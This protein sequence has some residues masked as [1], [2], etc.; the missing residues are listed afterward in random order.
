MQNINFHNADRSFVFKGKGKLKT[1]IDKLVKSENFQVEQLDY[2][3]CSDKYLLNINRKF[4]KHDFYT[5]IITFDLSEK[6]KIIQGEIYISLDRVID[7]SKSL[8]VKF[9]DE[10]LRVIFHGILHLCGYKDKKNSDKKIM[11]DKEDYYLALYS[12]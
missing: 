10:L 9:K 12:E 4:L 8:S 5:D 3:F 2:I 7:N 6:N 11:R 1:F